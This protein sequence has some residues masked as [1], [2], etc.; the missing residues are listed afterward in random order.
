MAATSSFNLAGI[1]SIVT[2]KKQL[3][4]PLSQIVS[5]L[6]I[7][8][9]EVLIPAGGALTSVPLNLSTGV[10]EALVVVLYAPKKLVVRY[11]TSDASHP[12]PVEMGIKGL[13]IL[14]LSPGEGIVAI[15]ASNP[16]ATEDVTLEYAVGAKAA[17]GDGDPD[18][19]DD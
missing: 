18:Y 8:T 11:T 10:T 19:W 9:P 14:T 16:S 17:V 2:A 4:W 5:Q 6:E 1:L 13:H 7:K 3:T 15:S 12:G